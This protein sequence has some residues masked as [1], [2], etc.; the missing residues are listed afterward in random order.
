MP[1]YQRKETRTEPAARLLPSPLVPEPIQVS[2][3]F[4][5]HLLNLEGRKKAQA[6]GEHFQLLLD[7]LKS[8]VPEGREMAL[9][10]TKLEEAC[11]Y[12]KAGMSR[13]VDN[14]AVTP[15]AQEGPAWAKLDGPQPPV[16]EVPRTLE[17]KKP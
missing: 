13:H 5:I 10:K 3:I 7:W 14:L 4:G 15:V 8:V 17:E 12:A 9:M 2:T 1:K 11:F 6:I 16:A